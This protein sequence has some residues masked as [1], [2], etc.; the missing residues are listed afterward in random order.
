MREMQG[1]VEILDPVKPEIEIVAQ[2]LRFP[3]GPIAMSDGS[4][5]VVEIGGGALSRVAPSGQIDM[6][7]DLGGGPNGAAIG[8]EGW[9]YVCNSGG[10]IHEEYAPGLKRTVAQSKTPGWI[11]RVNLRTGEVERVCEAVDGVRLQ[12]PNDLVFDRQG[13]FYFT[14]IG[15]RL[16]GQQGLGGVHYVSASGVARAVVREMTTPNGVG[17]APN[18]STLYVAETATRCVWAFDLVGP[19]EVSRR[20]FP[21]ASNGGRLLAGLP[22]FNRLD[23]MAIDIEGHVCVASL[24]NGGVWDIAPD[25]ATARHFMIDDHFTTNICFGGPDLGSAFVTMSASGRL[26]RFT[27]PRS[28]YPLN[29]GPAPEMGL[30]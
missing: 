14:D 17:L 16:E 30:W 21:P 27:W 11:E 3:E 5:I 7:A 28:G 20:P 23:S 4:I 12:S 26:G 19:G 13:G 24:V 18:E 15:K 22:G 2:G 6:I 8:P 25:G 29:F 9:C 1:E 10:W